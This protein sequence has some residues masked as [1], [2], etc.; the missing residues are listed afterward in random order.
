MPRTHL[1]TRTLYLPLP[2]PEVF[3]FFA[4]AENLG[5]ITPDELDFRIT[6]VPD[7]MAEGATIEYRLALFGVPFGWRT[8]ISYWEPP[9][10]FVDEQRRGPYKTWHHTH[11]FTEEGNGTRI[12]DAVRYALPLWPLGEVALPLVR[13]QLNRIFDYRQQATRRILLGDDTA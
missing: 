8:E 10:V 3:R 7:R 6:R 12:D 13:A 5:R 2:R 9:H 11:T 1:L 4:D